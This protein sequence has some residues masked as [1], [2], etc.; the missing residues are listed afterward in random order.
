MPRTDLDRKPLLPRAPLGYGKANRSRLLK[1]CEATVSK[2]GNSADAWTIWCCYGTY[3]SV[4]CVEQLPRTHNHNDWRS[5][6]PIQRRF[7]FSPAD[8]GTLRPTVTNDVV[9]NL[10]KYLYCL[11]HIAVPIRHC[12]YDRRHIRKYDSG[13]RM[14]QNAKPSGRRTWQHQITR[15]RRTL[16]ISYDADAPQCCGRRCRRIWLAALDLR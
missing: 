6:A 13:Y 10:L 16:Q 9:W 4:C 5:M 14:N 2:P 8:L 11:E 7:V 1:K 3:T 12:P 15:S